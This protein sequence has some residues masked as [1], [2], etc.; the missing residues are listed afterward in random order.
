MVKLDK[1]YTRGGDRGQTSLSD[2]QR[3]AKD[4]ARPAA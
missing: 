1:I 4:S 3:V 2:G